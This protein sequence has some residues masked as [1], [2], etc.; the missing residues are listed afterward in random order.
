MFLIVGRFGVT[1]NCLI[2]YLK[3]LRDPHSNACPGFAYAYPWPC[4]SCFCG[5][6][7][8]CAP[9]YKNLFSCQ[10]KSNAGYGVL[11]KIGTVPGF[12]NLKDANNPRLARRRRL[13]LRPL[14]VHSVLALN[15]SL[16]LHRLHRSPEIPPH[17]RSN[18]PAALK[19]FPPSIFKVS[20]FIQ[21]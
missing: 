10:D 15:C 4:S 2:P 16:K 14:C 8:S 11:G 1:K 7:N 20:S 19:P 17:E 5:S 18:P 3:S 6:P 13:A 9:S 21:I 12:R